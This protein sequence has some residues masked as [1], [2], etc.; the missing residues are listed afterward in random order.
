MFCSST[1][2]CVRRCGCGG[3]AGVWGCSFLLML[4]RRTSPFLLRPSLSVSGVVPR[5]AVLCTKSGHLYERGLITKHIEATG[6]D[7]VTNEEVTVDD[8]LAVKSECGVSRD[9]QRPLWHP[10]PPSPSSLPGAKAVKPRP[11]AAASVTDLL[12]LFQG[13]WDAL[14]LETYNLKEALEH[15]RQELSQALYQHDAA[16]RVIARLVKE[17]DTARSALANAQAALSSR[18]ASGAGEGAEAVGITD[19]VVQAMKDTAKVLQKK[20][21]KRSVDPE[22][23]TREAIGTYAAAGSHNL[24]RSDKPGITCVAVHKSV[25][26]LVLTGGVDRVGHVFNQVEGKVVAT[27]A[28]HSRRVTA[29]E[30]HPDAARGLIVTASN[31]KSMRV[32]VPTGSHEEPY[33]SALTVVPHSAEVTAVS[34]HPQGDFVATASADKRWAL[35]DIAVGRVLASV[36]DAS[37]DA[38]LTCA[39]F[40]PDG[41]IMATGAADSV[42]RV[43]DMKSQKVAAKF[44]GHTGGIPSLSFNENG[45]LMASASA[46]STVKVWDLRKLKVVQ[47]FSLPGPA[48]AVA[49]DT[50]GQYLAAGCS[51]GAAGGAGA[52]ELRVWLVKEWAELWKASPH[53]GEVTG[54]SFAPNAAYL[55]SSSMDRSLQFH[56]PPSA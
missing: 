1:Y 22:L 19:V 55:A 8:L 15:T 27:L 21:K 47:S 34:C 45:Y 40:H 13:E 3:G 29:V 18:G 26:H 24:H 20:R 44:E 28:G 17:R 30:F 25:P 23:L 51:G 41:M 11:V 35:T 42:V 16:C 54:V 33:A 32:W 46:D 50:S 10:P 4:S 9:W 12:G 14:M 53:S 5:D 7:P 37:V 31:D 43:W 52:G 38:S 39:S 49:W 56:A 6:R 48:T 2:A 36:G